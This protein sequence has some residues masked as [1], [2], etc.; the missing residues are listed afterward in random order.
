MTPMST[1]EADRHVRNALAQVV[2]GV[3]LDSLG[4]KDSL[5]DLLEMDSLDFLAFVEQL[6]AE[7][8]VRIDEDDYPKLTTLDSCLAFLGS[9]G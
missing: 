3:D 2:P 6:S 9:T 8:H 7:T 5:R 4:P 1:D